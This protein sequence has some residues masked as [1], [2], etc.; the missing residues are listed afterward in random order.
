[1][2]SKGLTCGQVDDVEQHVFALHHVHCDVGEANVVL[3]EVRHR[4]HGLDHLMHQQE[5]LGVL[6]VSL[7]QIHVGAGADG[8]TLWTSREKCSNMRKALH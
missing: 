7:G 4:H 5:L 2:Q 3:H 6:Q 1:M 8:A